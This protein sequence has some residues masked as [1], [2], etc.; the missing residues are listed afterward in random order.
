MRRALLL[1]ILLA[2][3]G[4]R[5]DEETR[6]AQE[7]LKS[8][9]FYFGE[10]DGEAGAETAA[11]IR[12]YQIRNGLEVTGALNQETLSSLKIAGEP[13]PAARAGTTSDTSVYKSDRDFLHQQEKPAPTAPTPTP[14]PPQERYAGT[15]AP[16]TPDYGVF[17]ARTPYENA[18]AEVQ[19]QMLRRAQETL[20]RYGYYRGIL[21]GFPGPA[22][23]RAIFL[24]Q[25]NA[26]LAATARLDTDTLAALRL[27]PGREVYAPRPYGAPL[28]G[29]WV[30]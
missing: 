14:E 25:Q 1:L 17:Y 19:V 10:V 21:D 8:R 20:S 6:A 23:R 22:T 16:S 29:I 7:Q 28:R 4:A 5:A 18:P 15:V 24:F 3:C 27:L 2:V 9:G 30:H 26:G 13:K 12:R 11:A